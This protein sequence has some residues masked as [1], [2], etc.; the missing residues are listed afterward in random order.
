MNATEI[1]ALARLVAGLPGFLRRP[2]DP[3]RARAIVEERRRRRGP[4]FLA[5]AR[6]AIYDHPTSPYRALLAHAGC[7]YGDLT[8][9]VERDGL[10]AALSALVRAGVYVTVDEFKGRR[11]L[12]RGTLTVDADAGAFANPLVTR[13]RLAQT[14][15]SR[16]PAMSVSLTLAFITDVSVDIRLTLDVWGPGPWELAYWNIPGAGVFYCP[17]YAKCGLPDARWFSPIDPADA[18][19][20][21]RH[22]WS[23]R[24]FSWVGRLAGARLPL[25]ETVAVDAPGVIL[26][27]LSDARARGRTPLLF[28]YTSPAVELCRAAVEAGMDLSGVELRVYGEPLTARRLQVIRESGA[29]ALGIYATMEAWRVGEPCLRPDAPDDAHLVDDISALVQPGTDGPSSL[30]PETLL[31]TSLRPS[32][33][34]I[35]LNT[36]LGDRATVITRRCGC[37]LDELGWT[38][39][40]S[41]IRSFEKLT[42]GGM[43]FLDADVI[44]ILDDV[45]PTRFGGGPTDYQ[46]VEDEAE[47]GRPRIRLQIHPRVGPLD[48]EGVSRAFL[49]AIGT[50]HG[51]ASLM[52]RMWSD[53]DV[54]TVERLAPLKTAAGKILH[55][56]SLVGGAGV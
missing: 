22:R 52:A 28:A 49:E 14:G 51:G 36:S 15:G 55:L 45:L 42:A 18:S 39:H 53:A 48:A 6:A 24:V 13:H 8:R 41:D 30:P 33:P 46:L 47:G 21:A 2:I 23:A 27:W 43:T 31:L 26:R 9:L 34:V 20:P 25:P 5:L 19:V 38:T 7:E 4:D 40:L 56:H 50:G 11:P 12:V 1:L 17:I 10:D 44:R 29:N 54:V 37:P 3:V 16:G 35:L 32:A